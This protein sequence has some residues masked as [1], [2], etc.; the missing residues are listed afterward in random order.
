MRLSRVASSANL[1]GSTSSTRSVASCNFSSPP[2]QFPWIAQQRAHAPQRKSLIRLLLM[3]VPNKYKECGVE[4]PKPRHCARRTRRS[5][6]AGSAKRDLWRLMRIGMISKAKRR[7]FLSA[8]LA[9]PIM[10]SSVSIGGQFQR[11]R[12][13]MR[14]RRTTCLPPAELRAMRAWIAIRGTSPGPLFPSRNGR[15]ISR[16]CFT[17]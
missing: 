3:R 16:K 5:S 6:P 2:L 7:D 14:A 11:R 10:F 12:R 9:G 15:G 4:R 1:P 17:C 8:F 13:C